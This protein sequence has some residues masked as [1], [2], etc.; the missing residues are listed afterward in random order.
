LAN[1]KGRDVL[2]IKEFTREEMDHAFEVAK[3]LE[4]VSWGQQY[5]DS[6][7]G[8]IMGSLFFE[9]S[10]RTRLS[11]ES[12]I[13]RLGGQVIG[14]ATPGVTRA[15]GPRAETLEDT[16]R[17]IDK[18]VDVIVMRHF[19]VGATFKAAKYSRVPVLSGGDGS[20]EHPT[21]AYLDLYTILRE[22]GR[23]DGLKIG[24]MGDL[25]HSRAMHSLAYALSKFNVDLY[26]ISPKEVAY[27]TEVLEYVKSNGRKYVEVIDPQ[28][29]ISELDALYPVRLHRD[30]FEQRGAKDEYDKIHGE[31]YKIGGPYRIDLKFLEKAKSD[32]IVMQPLPRT[33]ELGCI[34]L[35]EVDDTP[36][37]VYFKQVFYGLAVRV[38]L[39]ALVMG[40]E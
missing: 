25:K 4:P 20:G 12:A 23:I 14:F 30:R 27:P 39:L 38:A 21:Q 28:E 22:K 10:T 40:V 15:T 34:I 29:V 24:L 16:I 9:S 11:F 26:M 2:S 18:Y 7:K 3:K 8:K 31:Y 19:E 13:Q 36:F 33:D 37:A 32:L 6:L 5:N 1:F 17:T 35:E